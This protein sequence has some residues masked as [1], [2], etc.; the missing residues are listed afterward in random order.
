MQ[1]A[2]K[3]YAIG[4][5]CISLHMVAKYWPFKK[6]PVKNVQKS[7]VVFLLHLDIVNVT[8]NCR[9]IPGH[10]LLPFPCLCMCALSGLWGLAVK[11]LACHEVQLF[12]C[13]TPAYRY[14]QHLSLHCLLRLDS[15]CSAECQQ[16]QCI[17][18]ARAVLWKYMLS[19]QRVCV[20]WNFSSTCSTCN[21]G[22][23]MLLLIAST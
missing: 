22:T 10:A 5:I 18:A 16:L 14:V 2:Q 9:F 7:T 23:L 3:G 1:Y 12:L 8:V 15:V 6:M 11:C 13:A 21:I 17:I 19:G 20:L 4:C